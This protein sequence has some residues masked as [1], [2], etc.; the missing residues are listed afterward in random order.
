MKVRAKSLI[1]ASAI[2]TTLSP[3][4]ATY[5]GDD[6]GGLWNL[7]VTTNTKT[8]IGSNG[9]GTSFY[10]IAQDPISGT[11]Y[12][13]TSDGRLASINT[14]T[15]AGTVI[16]APGSF[17]NGLTFDSSGTLY[18][19]GNS[20]LY[21]INTATGATTLIGNIGYNSSGD[22][23]FNSS[24]QLFMSATGGPSGQDRLVSV[25]PTTGAGSLVGNIGFDTVYGLNYEGSTLYGFTLDEKTISINT[26]TGVGTFVANNGIRANGADGVGGVSVPDTGTTVS[27]F[28]IALS[29]LVLARR[30][31]A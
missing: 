9:L 28:G 6:S 7:D 1:A 2:L 22:L 27:L 21:T 23:A 12:G 14:T 30:R 26:A 4:Y 5:I 31:I 19:S 20:A 11:L 15:G 24:G 10:D 8:F 18:G 13:R 25:N 16:G 29:G 3:A 17:I